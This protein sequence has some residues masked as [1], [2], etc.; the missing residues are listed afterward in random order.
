M[1][2]PN[3][4]SASVKNYLVYFVFVHNQ[5]ALKLSIQ[6]IVNSSLL[7]NDYK[8]VNIILSNMCRV[9]PGQMGHTSE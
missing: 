1:C 7:H 3:Q 9:K 8:P 5:I 2:F 4:L 6:K